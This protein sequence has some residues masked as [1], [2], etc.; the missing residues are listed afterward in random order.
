MSGRN[1]KYLVNYQYYYNKYNIHKTS[2]SRLN[3]FYISCFP[4]IK[5]IRF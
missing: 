5:F 1:V 4:K 2:L 3:N